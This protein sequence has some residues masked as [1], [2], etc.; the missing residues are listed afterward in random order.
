[1]WNLLHLSFHA[2]TTNGLSLVSIGQQW[3][4]LNLQNKEPIQPYPSTWESLGCHYVQDSLHRWCMWEYFDDPRHQTCCC[5]TIRNA[6]CNKVMQFSKRPNSASGRCNARVLKYHNT[7]INPWY[8]LRGEFVYNSKT[9]CW[10]L[11]LAAT[12]LSMTGKVFGTLSL[13]LQI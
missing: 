1:M 12:A 5:V 6:E 3:R 4:V 10:T 8:F 2:W 13:Y 7:W 9:L 11:W